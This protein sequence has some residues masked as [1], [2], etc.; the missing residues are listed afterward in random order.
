MDLMGVREPCILGGC[1]GSMLYDMHQA[2]AG[3]HGSTM[4]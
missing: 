4:M 2:T 3:Q 1:P